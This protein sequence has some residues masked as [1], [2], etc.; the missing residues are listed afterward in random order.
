MADQVSTSYLSQLTGIDR[1]TIQKRCEG[2]ETKPGPKQAKT[3]NSEQALQ[4][5]YLG[6]GNFQSSSKEQARLHHFRANIEELREAQMRGELMP[7]SEVVGAVSSMIA[8]A[9]AKLLS[10]P[11]RVAQSL[12]VEPEVRRQAQDMI[13]TEVFSSL[14]ELSEY[15]LPGAPGVDSDLESAAEDDG[16]RVGGRKEVSKPRGKRGAGKVAKQ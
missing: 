14:D 1:K 4:A 5:I 16:Q 6:D 11:S 2:L 12:P 13:Q 8:E 15:R 9:K 3:Y 7:M 10:L